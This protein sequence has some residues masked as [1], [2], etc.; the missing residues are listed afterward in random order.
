MYEIHVLENLNLQHVAIE[1]TCSKRSIALNLS[2]W[3]PVP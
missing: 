1:D 3:A 2:E